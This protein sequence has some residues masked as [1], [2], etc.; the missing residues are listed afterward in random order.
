MFTSW[1][2]NSVPYA[3]TPAAAVGI[4]SDNTY[5]ATFTLP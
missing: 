2:C 3:T 5:R 1:S 4:N